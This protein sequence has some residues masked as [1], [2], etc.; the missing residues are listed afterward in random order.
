MTT[1]GT[2]IGYKFELSN[3]GDGSLIHVAENQHVYRS[4][5]NSMMV[6]KKVAENWTG[7]HFDHDLIFHQTDNDYVSG[8]SGGALFALHFIS[9]LTGIK[10]RKDTTGSAAITE[11]GQI[12]QVSSISEKMEAAKSSGYTH[13]IGAANQPIE[14]EI[15]GISIIKSHNI[16]EVWAYASHCSCKACN[17]RRSKGIE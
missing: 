15:P 13:F 12:I 3:M 17:W 6:G 2:L 14:R 9:M 7:K 1:R 16:E 5:W 4:A 10:L 11:S 8:G